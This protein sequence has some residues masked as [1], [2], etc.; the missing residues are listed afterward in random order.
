MAKIYKTMDGNEAAAYAS[1]AFTE[2]AG[3]YPITP[4][5]PMAEHTDAWAAAG[6]KNLFGMPV[7]VVEMQSEAGAAGS[8]H[9]SL[10]SGALTTTYTA[11]QGLL[12]KIPNMYKIAGE[13]LP[14][15]IHVAAR[16]LAAQALSIF[17]DHQDIYACRATG[18][19]M[20]AA[21]SVQEVMDLAGVAHL[22]AIKGRVPFLHF[23]DGFRTSHE[24]QKVEV[25]D[26]AVFE[27]LLDKKAVAD[28]RAAALSSNS[29]K[30]RGTAQNDDIYFQ[31]REL[32]NTYYNALPDIV[33]DYMKEISAVT[34]R[35]YAP[36]TYYGDERATDIIVAMGSVCECAKEVVDHL[37]KQ[38]QKV[39][40]LCVHLYRPF[41]ADYF[42]DALP[43]SVE[44]IAVLDRT[45][46]P[47][48]LGEPLYLDVCAL[49]AGK[50]NAPKIIGGRYGL[51]SKD[52]SPDQ[53]I[54]VFK[55]LASKESK[56]GFT[57]GIND[58]ITFTSLECGEKISLA[59]SDA[60]E[61][62]FYGLGSDGTVGANKNSIKIIGDKTDFYAQAYFAYDSK[63]SGGYTRSHLRFSKNPIRSTYL[64]SNPDF[65]ACSV[66]AYLEI[67]DVLAGIKE[68][69]TFLLNSIWDA[70]TTAKNLPN[71]VKRIL[72]QKKVNFYIINATKLAA[73][74][75]LRGRTNTIMQSAFFKLANIIP[76]EDARKYMK[77]YAHKTYA[78]KGD[79]VV[80]M[81]YKAIDEGADGL[82][83]V[84]IDPSWASLN[85]EMGAGIPNYKG[86][87][88]VEKIAKVMNSGRGDE[89]AV[90]AFVGYEDGH[91]ESGTTQY[92]KRGV[93]VMV[94]KWIK[95]N[96]IQCNECAFVC[97]HAVIR[98]F[99]LDESEIAAAPDS[100]KNSL[101]DAKGKELKEL[102][103]KIQVSPLDCTGCELC[104]TNCPSKEKSLVMVP[105]DEELNNNEQKN[106]DY[107]FNKVR[108]KDDLMSKETPKGAMFAEPLFEFHGA[109]P[110]CGETPYLTTLT[111]LFGEHLIIANATGCSSIYG[112]SAPSTPYKAS[113]SGKGVAWANS[114]FEDNAEF[115]LGMHVANSVLRNRVEKIIRENLENKELGNGIIA[116]FK[117]WL[118]FRDDTLKSMAIYDKL[119]P[120]LEENKNN[121]VCAELL[122]LKNFISKSSHWI[123]GGDGWAYDIGYG[124]LD[125]A[126][127][128]GED[129]NILV[130]DTEVYS[131]TGGQ[132]SKSSRT[133]SVA[134][135]SAAGKPV[136]KKD[137]GAIA[138]MSGNVFVAQINSNA[139]QAQVIKAFIAA[140]NHKGPSLI[141][142]YSPCIAHGIAHGMSN[143]GNQGELATKCGYWPTYTYNPELKAQGKNPLKIT[144]PEPKWESYEEFL[145]NETRYSSLKKQNPE[146]AS[147]LLEQNKK[148]AMAKYRELKRRANADYSDEISQ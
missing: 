60:T 117:D 50:E 123:V 17:G 130:L 78:K 99:L 120:I 71:H 69:G 34:G 83:K 21:N 121:A 46:E 25:M 136:S 94:P 88:F 67:Y 57:V 66:A 100:V 38:G 82:I 143:S 36:F 93:G 135:F 2:V 70:E 22:S 63:K 111:R 4:S 77:E 137:L 52:V 147:E 31:T 96:C 81:N 76:F 56:N 129:I 23:F 91:F 41:S 85:D 105:L 125:H 108:Y 24:I 90:S 62:L 20:L 59:N 92:E 64:V 84:E 28:F 79:S 132:S 19:A 14:C 72:A 110:G 141:I 11:S 47:G 146:Q 89:L 40:V 37:N 128:S 15:V 115:G 98:P 44:R 55:N 61:C 18:F 106:A 10:Q 119:V 148:E 86:S 122:E 49:F 33:A 114:L 58:D 74:I 140:Q 26:Y 29:P 73:Q 45:K 43:K 97:P 13:L 124:G 116:L 12:L 109:C 107:L 138:M 48:S 53:I 39:G 42:F 95:E 134:Q 68:G 27:R 103:Y 104:A 51:S 139:N 112:G 8:V 126:L 65:V 35:D 6:K 131:N 87:E 5:S 113:K 145:L 16:S 101:L 142:A 118:E 54:A 80:E 1:Y 127:A 9:G 144:S 3:I 75:G 32:A 133:G 102:K 30:T 7:K